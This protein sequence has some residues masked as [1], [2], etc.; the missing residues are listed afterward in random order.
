MAKAKLSRDA[1]RF[2]VEQKND[3]SK[4]ITWSEL[5][6]ALKQRFDV[7]ITE[8]SIG[9]TYRK[10][11][12]SFEPVTNNPQPIQVKQNESK[13]AVGGNLTEHRKLFSNTSE[14][15]KGGF[16]ETV[17]ENLTKEQIK[18]LTSGE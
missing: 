3:T 12:D 10:Y 5:V 11:K 2:I 6:S 14:N 1:I 4:V 7:E 18:A 9:R 16:D 13:P 17:S 15:K 8:Q